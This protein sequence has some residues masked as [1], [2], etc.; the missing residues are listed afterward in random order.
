MRNIKTG[1]GNYKRWFQYEKKHGNIKNGVRQL[2]LKDFKLMNESGVT[3]TEILN[4]QKMISG[5]YKV[6]QK[7][8]KAYKKL[9]LKADESL[10][11]EGTWFG[12]GSQNEAGLSYHRTLSGLMKDK[13]ALHFLIS[14]RTVEEG[15]RKEVLAD[16]GYTE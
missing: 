3:T 9:K 1:Y 2:T 5:G 12:R 15:D 7:T 8:W 13:H 4:M 10:V 6:K 11:Q 16:Y 14:L